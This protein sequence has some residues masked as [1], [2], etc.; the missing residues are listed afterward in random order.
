MK[1]DIGMT[2]K[3]RK[4]VADEITNFLAD[5]YALYLKTQNFHWN[6]VGPQFF[7]LHVLFQK[8][9]EEMAEA[10]DEI[11]E[12]VRT[13]GFYAEGSFSAF[14][15]RTTISEENK[16]VKQDDMIKKLVKDHELIAKKYRPLILLAQE[17]HDEMTADLVIKRLEVH[18][19][20]AWLLRSH[21]N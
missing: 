3:E 12:R 8:Q 14:K 15:K 6:M 21:L 1:V 7:S 2:E 10:I 4:K 18:E 19:K 9:Y 16:P 17:H 13:L 11:A 5:T 20:A